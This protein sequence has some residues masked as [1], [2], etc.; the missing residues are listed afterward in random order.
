MASYVSDDTLNIAVDAITDQTVQV[1]VHSG[2]PGN[3]G[4]SNRIGSASVDHPASE[5]T[6]G[7]GG[8]AETNTDSAFGVL[9]SSNSQTVTH[10]SLWASTTF[11]SWGDLAS[12][13]TVAAGESFTINSGTVEFRASRP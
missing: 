13:V 9:D 4:T 11:L 2:S 6:A 10:Y 8:V 3:S 7:A 5:W 1:R 12:S